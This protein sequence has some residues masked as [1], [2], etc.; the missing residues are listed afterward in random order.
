[1]KSW[2][3]LRANQ[4]RTSIV[5]SSELTVKVYGGVPL[6]GFN[7]ISVHYVCVSITAE[8]LADH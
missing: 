2:G 5:A 1:M 7:E 6:V 3:N 8:V 4:Y